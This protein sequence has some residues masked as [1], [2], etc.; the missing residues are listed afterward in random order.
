V[1][2]SNPGNFLNPKNLIPTVLTGGLY[3]GLKEYAA[4]AKPPSMPNAP[5][6]PDPAAVPTVSDPNPAETMQQRQKKLAAL[7]YGFA[8]TMTSKSN[9]GAP[10]MTPTATGLKTKTGQ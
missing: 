10:L 7:Q 2:S 6:P 1:G 9:I 3:Y 4:N 8:S 5:P